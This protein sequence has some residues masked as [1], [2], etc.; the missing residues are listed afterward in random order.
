M[1]SIVE[2]STYRIFQILLTL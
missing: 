1:R 2:R